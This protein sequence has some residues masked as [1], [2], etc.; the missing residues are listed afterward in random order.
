MEAGAFAS[1]VARGE[2][3]GLDVVVKELLAEGRP[4]PTAVA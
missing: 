2:T 4:H 3:K 1:A